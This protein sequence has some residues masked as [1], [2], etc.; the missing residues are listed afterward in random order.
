MEDP[1]KMLLSRPK[2]NPDESLVGYFHR[3]AHLNGFQKVNAFLCHLL[4]R[5]TDIKSLQTL[6]ITREVTKALLLVTG[7]RRSWPLDFEGS[8][9]LIRSDGLSLKICVECFS[10]RPHIKWEWLAKNNSVC[11]EHKRCLEYVPNIDLNSEHYPK[12]ACFIIF[13]TAIASVVISRIALWSFAFAILRLCFTTLV[14]Y[15]TKPGHSSYIVDRK[16]GYT[17]D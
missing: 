9:R 1:R 7:N 10:S 5:K 6:K 17:A 12:Q 2:L 13:W 16:G 8:H 3:V 15:F 4:G 14:V 11:H